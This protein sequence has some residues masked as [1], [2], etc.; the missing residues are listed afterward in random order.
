MNYKNLIISYAEKISD[1][2]GVPFSE[3]N[4]TNNALN[5]IKKYEKQYQLECVKSDLMDKSMLCENKIKKGF[6]ILTNCWKTFRLDNF[7]IKK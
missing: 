1:F 7:S 3:S 6:I 2:I 4:D 5:F